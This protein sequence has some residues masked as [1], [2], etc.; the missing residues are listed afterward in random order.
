MFLAVRNGCFHF[1][2][3]Y[4]SSLRSDKPLS[5]FGLVLPSKENPMNRKQ[6]L[7][8]HLRHLAL[9]AWDRLLDLWNIAVPVFIVSGLIVACLKFWWWVL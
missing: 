8:L 6:L 4:L 7:K 3:H 1:H 2:Y 9:S 5:T